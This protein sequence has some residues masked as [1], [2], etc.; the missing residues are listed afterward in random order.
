MFVVGD[1]TET[2]AVR[3]VPALDP[4]VCNTSRSLVRISPTV[5]VECMGGTINR[6]YSS[7]HSAVFCDI[8]SLKGSVCLRYTFSKR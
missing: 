4:G 8:P 7:E 2:H 1:V 5:Q 6:F 3:E